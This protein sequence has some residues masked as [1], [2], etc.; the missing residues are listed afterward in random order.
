MHTMVEIVRQ[1]GSLFY[2]RW[3][4]DE[5]GRRSKHSTSKTTT[6]ISHLIH[7]QVGYGVQVIACRHTIS[8]ANPSMPDFVL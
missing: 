1:V 6:L 3:K 8:T 4:R 5:A 7:A 2:F